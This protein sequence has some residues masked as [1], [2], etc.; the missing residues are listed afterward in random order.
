MRGFPFLFAH[1]QMIVTRRTPPVDACRGFA[2]NETPVLPEVFTSA[3]AAAS[4]QTVNHGCSDAARFKNEARHRRRQ[5]PAFADRAGDC[6]SIVL[7]RGVVC[8]S[9]ADLP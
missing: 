4:M 8:H 2:G 6:T 7:L 3:G 1:I 5:R 9:S